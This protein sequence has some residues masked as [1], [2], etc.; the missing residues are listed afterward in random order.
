MQGLD[1]AGE[2]GW[3]VEALAGGRPLKQVLEVRTRRRPFDL[4]IHGERVGE[5]A[6]DDTVI[7]VDTSADGSA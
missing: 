5:L 3:R 4:A 1:R 7:A 6:L 2:V